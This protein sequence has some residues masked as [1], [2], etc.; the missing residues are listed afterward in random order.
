[1]DVKTP[2]NNFFNYHKKSSDNTFASVFSFCST[3]IEL[4]LQ[5]PDPLPGL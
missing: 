3:E 2:G 5:P 1:M 4:H